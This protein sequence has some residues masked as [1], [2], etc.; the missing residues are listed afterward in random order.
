MNVSPLSLATAL[1]LSAITVG[2]GALTS[3]VAGP[4]HTGVITTQGP[5]R[6]LARDNLIGVK[7][8]DSDNIIIGDVED[9]IIDSTNRVIGVVVGTGGV[10][11]IGEKRVGVRLTTLNFEEA[12]GTTYAVLSG[13]S[14]ED[15]DNAPAFARAKPQKSLLQR[16]KEKAQE[17]T[18]KTTATSKDV[19]EKAKPTLDAAKET[20]KET[21]EKAKDVAKDAVSPTP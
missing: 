12:D 7:V 10:L 3:A 21:Y 13:M 19:Y 9:L 17:L 6:Y 5:D 2:A 11:G 1:T 4:V 18:D 14:K 15:L 8:H 16:A 20:V